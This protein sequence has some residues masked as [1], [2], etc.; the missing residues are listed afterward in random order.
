MSVFVTHSK[1]K[2]ALHELQTGPGPRLLIL[3]ALGERSPSEVPPELRAWPGSVFALDFTGHGQS[4]IPGG[5]G[6]TSEI[7]MG[8]ADAALAL[9]GEATVVGYGLG[10]YVALLIAGARPKLVRGAVLCDGPGLAGGGDE[11]GPI[12]VR[13]VTERHEAPDPFALVELSGD[14]RPSRY[15]ASFAQLAVDGSDL[16]NPI[17]VVA[18]ARP[19]W[20][21]AILA[22]R[23]IAESPSLAEA[24]A[25][26]AGG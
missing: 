13:G 14:L 26:Y 20:L 25:S 21:A 12:V 16:N 23:G 17:L 22:V 4:S 8:D 15:A 19:D 18:K 7:L 6:Y 11:P 5:G 9:I 3:H 1:T 10:A 2:L 24:V